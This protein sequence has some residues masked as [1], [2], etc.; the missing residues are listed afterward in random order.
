MFASKNSL[1]VFVSIPW[2]VVS[3][4]KKLTAEAR[5]HGEKFVCKEYFKKHFG[6][7][8]FVFYPKP[9]T[10]LVAATGRARNITCITINGCEKL[11]GRLTLNSGIKPYFFAGLKPTCFWIKL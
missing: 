11:S 10:S 2:P 7:S 8:L 3:C 6:H 5:R 1:K 4:C 9:E